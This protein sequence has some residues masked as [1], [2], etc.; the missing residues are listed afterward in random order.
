M[1]TCIQVLSVC[2]IVMY[3]PFCVGG[4]DYTEVVEEHLEFNVTTNRHCIDVSLLDDNLDEDTE[5]FS[6]VLVGDEVEKKE[7]KIIILDNGKKA[8]SGWSVCSA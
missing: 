2:R 1:Y 4:A 7:V 3:S 6:V 8:K 5:I